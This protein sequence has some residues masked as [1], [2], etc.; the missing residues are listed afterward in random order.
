MT[1][2]GSSDFLSSAEILFSL[3]WFS[4]ENSNLVLFH[5]ILILEN[6]SKFDIIVLLK[7]VAGRN[8]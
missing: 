5:R 4:W 2:I 3:Y 1:W 8:L 7:G 6:F